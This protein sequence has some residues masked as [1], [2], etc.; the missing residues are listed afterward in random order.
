MVEHHDRA[1]L[2][3]QSDEG[4]LERIAGEHRS[5]WVGRGRLVRR[6]LTDV[7][8]PSTLAGLL[9]RG[10]HHEPV[11]PGVEP[12]EVP[13]PWQVPPDA[14]QRALDGILGGVEVAQDPMRHPEQGTG[15]VRRQELV[16]LPVAVACPFHQTSVHRT[17]I[18]RVSG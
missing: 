9:E 5:G 1:V 13:Q 18:V 2:G 15:H 3:R 17:S 4:A 11:A 12:V 6:Q 7:G 16:R 14:D 8:V 10:A